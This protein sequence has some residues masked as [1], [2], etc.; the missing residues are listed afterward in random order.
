MTKFRKNFILFR[1]S[2]ILTFS[3]N[4]SSSFCCSSVPDSDSFVPR[5][6]REKLRVR[7]MPNQLVNRI[8]VSL[9]RVFWKRFGWDV[10]VV[11]IFSYLKVDISSGL[12]GWE[13]VHTG[14][15]Y[16]SEPVRLPFTRRS[17]SSVKT[18]AVL[19]RLP[20]AS[21]FPSADQATVWTFPEWPANSL[22]REWSLKYWLYLST[23]SE[24]NILNFILRLEFF[25]QNWQKKITVFKQILFGRTGYWLF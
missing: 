21:L 20:D 9:E 5:S 2:L 16:R 19:S 3:L 4:S 7:R 11:G 24:L 18:Q 23:I 8:P 13:R 12:K 22:T 15:S 1:F 10:Q 6:G 14:C 25:K 17:L